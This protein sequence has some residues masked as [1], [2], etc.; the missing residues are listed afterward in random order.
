MKGEQLCRVAIQGDTV[1]VRRLLSTPDAQSF[2]NYQDTQGLTPLHYSADF[3]H[4]AVTKPL[5]AG[6]SQVYLQDEKGCT[7]LYLAAQN[8][9]VSVTGQLIAARWH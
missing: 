9:H 4:D 7:P 3:G 6:H 5:I 2:I 1:T 8:G